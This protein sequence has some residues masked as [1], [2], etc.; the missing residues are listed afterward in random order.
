[1]RND[2][3]IE[4]LLESKSKRGSVRYNP[5]S[6]PSKRI[7]VNNLERS[8]IDSISSRIGSS[9]SLRRSSVVAEELS[10][11]IEGSKRLSSRLLP[12][13]SEDFDRNAGL[14]GIDLK[15]LSGESIEDVVLSSILYDV[16]NYI[17][18]PI[19][20]VSCKNRVFESKSHSCFVGREFTDCLCLAL[21][22]TKE[23]A[24]YLLKGLVKLGELQ[25]VSGRLESSVD[26]KDT[27]FK[28]VDSRYEVLNKV[29]RGKVAGSTR[30]PEE[31]G[32]NAVYLVK[33]MM[34]EFPLNPV[35]GYV[36]MCSCNN[37]NCNLYILTLSP[38]P[39]N[40][41]QSG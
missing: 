16:L 8:A 37:V 2:K 13:T 4:L 26:F 33:N 10:A 29:R 36:L 28:F 39:C 19:C 11:K 7:S 23:A 18:N 20:G 15:D 35:T 24:F 38:V 27:Y 32:V 40:R 1:M 12:T 3:F 34:E 9:S 41:M 25:V 6:L 30:S 17:N 21:G 31:V 14:A 5:S 22:C